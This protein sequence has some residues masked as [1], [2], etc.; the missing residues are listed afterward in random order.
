[1]PQS[2]P[3]AAFVFGAILFLI[4][5]TKGG[6]KLFGTEVSGTAEGAMRMIAGAAGALLIA[7]GL[8]KGSAP[9]GLIA[10][11]E[12]TSQVTPTRSDS[13]STDGSAPAGHRTETQPSPPAVTPG[14]AAAGFVSD[15]EDSVRLVSMTPPPGTYL[16]RLIRQPI[17]VVLEYSLV[18]ESSALLSVSVAQIRQSAAGCST[19]AGQLTDATSIPIMHGRHS[20]SVTVS[21]SGDTPE[22]TKGQTDMQGYLK[23]VPMFWQSLGGSRGERIRQFNGYDAFCLKFGS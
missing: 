23:L 21:W 12:P 17:N 18:S 1:M 6:F 3:L 7:F 20:V 10:T 22:A 19:N 15:T 4:A 9:G 16:H 13:D 2:I 11:P 14:S 8:W 5:L